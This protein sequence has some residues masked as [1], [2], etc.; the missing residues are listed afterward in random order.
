MGNF[1]LRSLSV[2]ASECVCVGVRIQ[3]VVECIWGDS[4][5]MLCILLLRILLQILISPDH[6]V[7]AV[8]TRGISR[9]RVART[10]DIVLRPLEF[11]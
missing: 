7:F 10:S 6:G 5:S 11:F 2:E 1:M 9:T 3:M 4:P 8:E